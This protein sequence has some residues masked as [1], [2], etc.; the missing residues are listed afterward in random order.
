M[1]GEWFL[2]RDGCD[3]GDSRMATLGA[4]V[5][6]TAAAGAASAAAVLV[7]AV[8][9]WNSEQLDHPDQGVRLLR[10]EHEPRKDIDDL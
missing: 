9:H 6:G 2:G 10:V 3:G 5:T 4:A 8:G 1:V 7:W